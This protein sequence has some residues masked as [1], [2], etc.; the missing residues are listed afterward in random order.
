MRFKDVANHPNVVM[1]TVEDALIT[2]KGKRIENRN[3]SQNMPGVPAT[4][5]YRTDE[6]TGPTLDK[7]AN[8]DENTTGK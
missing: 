6:R 8:D 7:S 3:E 4:Q 1:V 2:Y 5:Q